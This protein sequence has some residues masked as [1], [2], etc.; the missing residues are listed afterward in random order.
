MLLLKFYS[1]ECIL[2]KENGSGNYSSESGHGVPKDKD[3]FESV[4]YSHENEFEQS[5]NN[6]NI[7]QPQQ[8]QNKAKSIIISNS[9]SNISPSMDTVPVPLPPIPTQLISPATK[10][11]NT[12]VESNTP[13][14]DHP[15]PLATS[16]VP[17]IEKVPQKAVHPFINPESPD[18]PAFY[19]NPEEE[20]AERQ[21]DDQ[22][23]DE[24][25]DEILALNDMLDSGQVGIAGLSR[26]E[27][28][29]LSLFFESVKEDG[30]DA[31]R[32]RVQEDVGRLLLQKKKES[33]DS[34][35]VSEEMVVEVQV[36]KK[37]LCRSSF[38]T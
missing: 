17:L 24:D 28:E 26:E 1:N 5:N 30:V 36:Q 4:Q 12:N 11:N 25:G 22:G 35:T 7:Y 34:E 20:I 31:V 29:E 27:D 38:S 10:T 6:L 13:S 32:Q 8:N 14:F 23:H 21:G 3:S 9:D 15:L 18:E 37:Y 33:R 19:T 16:N 2:D